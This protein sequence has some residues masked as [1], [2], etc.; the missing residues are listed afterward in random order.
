MLENTDILEAAV[1]IWN[2]AKKAMGFAGDRMKS[3]DAK[4]AE[5]KKL[6]NLSQQMKTQLSSS[7]SID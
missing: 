1:G 3:D 5:Y 4:T 7:L 6:A 2:F